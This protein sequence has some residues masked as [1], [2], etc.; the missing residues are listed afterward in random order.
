MLF[1]TMRLAT[2]SQGNNFALLLT[3]VVLLWLGSAYSAFAL[4]PAAGNGIGEALSA[5]GVIARLFAAVLGD[6]SPFAVI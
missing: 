5:A 3:L 2:T 1:S 4:A 6:I